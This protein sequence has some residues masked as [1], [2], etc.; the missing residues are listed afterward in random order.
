M[1]TEH[2]G[3]ERICTVKGT[4]SHK[5]ITDRRPHQRYKFFQF[6][7]C[8]R[9]H[10]AAAH[11]NIRFFRFF[12]VRKRRL[13]L[14]LRDRMC[15]ARCLFYHSRL[16]LR[17]IC[18]HILRNIDKHRTRSAF[19]CNGKCTADRR[20]QITHILDDKVMF[21]DRHCHSGNIN[22]LKTVFSQQRYTN[23]TG[24]RHHRNRIHIG[25]C[26]TGDQIGRTRSGGCKTHTD[27]SGASRI[28]VR[29][30]AGPLFMG[31]QNVSD[32]ITMLI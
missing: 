24:D 8:T 3:I 27:F 29:R 28:T 2:S 11:K 22:L 10:C 14:L 6:L 16:I 21:C 18:C 4:L 30:M 17:F 12:H 19:F 15:T 25:R 26:D 32:F 31:G 23:I 13:D 9:D 7:R 5:G 1:H 20:C